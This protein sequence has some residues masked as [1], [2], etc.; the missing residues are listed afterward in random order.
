METH[1]AVVYVTPSPEATVLRLKNEH[2]DNSEVI[3]RITDTLAI[4]EVRK[5]IE[6]SYQTPGD[7]SYRLLVV[8]AN[9]IASEAQQALLKIL[10]E[11]PA[12]TRFA[13][14]LPDATTLLP[15]VRS[16]VLIVNCTD[17]EEVDSS[18]FSMFLSLSVPERLLYIAEIAK[19]KDDSTYQALFSGLTNYALDL[20]IATPLSIR[21][22]IAGSL[23]HLRLRGASKK[24][25][26]EELAL[27]LPV[28]RTA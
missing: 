18:A 24:M 16:R 8:V 23:R 21:Q 22:V 19:K 15:T 12:T 13:V 17:E 11:P 25:L 27:S 5:L 1:H 28:T 9:Q 26:W 7:K 4:S 14:V 20:P 2:A 3:V 10:E 6:Q